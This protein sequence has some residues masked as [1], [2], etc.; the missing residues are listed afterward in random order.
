M[1][2]VISRQ[3]FQ[4]SK[5]Q[6]RL[7]LSDKQLAFAI[8]GLT[9]NERSRLIARQYFVEGKSISEIASALG[10]SQPHVS[11]LVLRM[12]NNF[13]TNLELR[14]MRIEVF[15]TPIPDSDDS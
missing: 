3:I 1:D 6:V 11:Q 15:I 12:E 14:R 7:L 5:V 10:V 2:R 8:D 4:A 13:K 9:L